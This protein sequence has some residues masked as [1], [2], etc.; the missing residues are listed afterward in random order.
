MFSYSAWPSARIV[1]STPLQRG[2]VRDITETPRTTEVRWP[3]CPYDDDTLSTGQ[4]GHGASSEWADSAATNSET[5]LRMH[6]VP[7]I[8]PTLES[9]ATER[10]EPT[11]PSESAPHSPGLHACTHGAE[12]PRFTLI[13]RGLKVKASLAA[14]PTAVR[15]WFIYAAAVGWLCVP[16]FAAIRGTLAKRVIPCLDVDRGRV[17]KGT[18]FL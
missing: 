14:G 17:V 2:L 13:G 9:R 15:L 6:S 1:G 18:N 12:R 11:I 10:P 3:A 8:R 5:G 16:G 4:C 7:N